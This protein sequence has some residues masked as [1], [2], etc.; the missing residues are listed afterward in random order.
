MNIG[1]FRIMQIIA[2]FTILGILSSIAVLAW[3]QSQH[4]PYKKVQHEILLNSD[5][6][7]SQLTLPDSMKSWNTQ[8]LKVLN[9]WLKDLT[10]SEAQ[11]FINNLHEIIQEAQSDPS[12]NI[13]SIVNT[14][15]QMYLSDIAKR[16]NDSLQKTFKIIFI[17]I[18]ILTIMVILVLLGLYS[19]VLNVKTI[20][21]T[22]L[23]IDQIGAAI[24]VQNK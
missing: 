20:T 13:N 12:A 17:M 18:G 2:I 3:P 5:G 8:S 7:S 16:Q 4:I 15:K 9:G 23:D 10:D 21:D 6:R 24:Q 19:I 1:L 22:V 14:Y 11:H